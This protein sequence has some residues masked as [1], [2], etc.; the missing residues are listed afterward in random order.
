MGN[1][2]RQLLNSEK[3]VY[4]IANQP[5]LFGHILGMEKLNE[6]HTE[7]IR[8]IWDSK[9]PRA[10][11]AYRG[12]YKTTSI[13]VLGSLRWFFFNPN[14]RIALVRKH[15]ENAADVVN[16]VAA[17]MDLPATQ[18]A[19][20]YRYGDYIRFKVRREG[21]LLLNF[22]KNISSEPSMLAL[23]IN[24]EFTGKHFDKI[25]SDDFVTI[26]D[27]VS[28]AER[29]NTKTVVMELATNII[30][31]GKGS[32]WIG[33]PW[34]RDDAW[35]IVRSFC[36]IAKYPVGQ[37]NFI[38]DEEV[39]KKRRTTTPRMFAANY[40]LDLISDKSL[41]FQDP[42]YADEWDYNVRGVVAQIDAAYDGDHYCALTIAAPL[43]GAGN[44]TYYQA[45]GFA[46]PGNIRDWYDE[47]V[48]LCKKYHVSC[49]YEEVNADKGMSAKDLAA[50][51]I[52]VRSYGE[53]QNKHLKISTCLYKAWRYIEW[54]RETDAQYM[55]QILDYREG[56]APDDAPDSAASLFREA[57]GMS[58]AL[59][60]GL[61]E[62]M[63]AR[64]RRN[65]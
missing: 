61:R 49:L 21:R 44:E 4:L 42:A 11:Q 16:S 52:K 45:I 59:D 20:K 51:G 56:S 46:Y 12:S 15:F 32:G 22:K 5:H 53:K 39:E 3:S 31:P 14:D 30:D 40:N 47:I 57:F 1:E 27:Y 38:G 50:K 8:Y 35:G 24:G 62:Q 65:D 58:T 60:D 23:G 19:F 37:Y 10:L 17:A 54:S 48:R 55:S 26:K 18:E 36:P 43:R 33:T 41:L 63:A 64:R 9:T 34:H 6:V 13:C 28:R 29:N 25:I 7:W 2:W